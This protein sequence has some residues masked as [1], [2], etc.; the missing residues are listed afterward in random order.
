MFNFNPDPKLHEFWCIKGN[1]NNE[2][3]SYFELA[4]KRTDSDNG[5][6]TGSSYRLVNGRTGESIGWYSLTYLRSHYAPWK[7]PWKTQR[8]WAKQYGFIFKEE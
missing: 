1:E 5:I 6:A 7:D 3:A 8:V 2:K 4:E